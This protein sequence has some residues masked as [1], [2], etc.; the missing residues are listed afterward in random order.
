MVPTKV[1]VISARRRSRRSASVWGQ[2]ATWSML[3]VATPAISEV[4]TYWPGGVISSRSPSWRV[5]GG[6][7]SRSRVSV[8]AGVSRPNSARPV[9]SSATK[10]LAWRNASWLRNVSMV[11]GL[12]GVSGLASACQVPASVRWICQALSPPAR[13]TAVIA[14]RSKPSSD[15][16]RSV[17]SVG[18]RLL[19]RSALITRAVSPSLRRA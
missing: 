15:L 13:L 16:S 5:R 10:A 18:V 8:R 9:W 6:S 12:R 14:S 17:K 11:L 2:V 4:A 3:I 1:G 19:A 7:L